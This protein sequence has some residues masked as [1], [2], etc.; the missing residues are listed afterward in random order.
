MSGNRWSEQGEWL[1]RG[2]VEARLPDFGVFA[3][4]SHHGPVFRM[5]ASKHDFL[6]IFYILRGSGRIVIEDDVDLCDAGDVVVVPVGSKHWIED[7]PAAPLSLHG[8]CVASRVW[9]QEPSLLNHLPAG[10]LPLSGLATAQV[11]TDLR[12]LLFE[13]SFERPGGISALLG[14]TL[15]LLALLAR[16]RATLSGILRS[17]P[18]R[19]RRGTGR[20]SS[21]MLP[22]SGSGSSSRPISTP[23]PTASG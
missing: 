16:T 5:A 22:N 8:L 13:Q 6:E 18:T 14:L 9:R 17:G 3:L 19:P 20:L 10:R 15:Q 4:E 1:R 21:V 11:R 12:R 23:W 7:A 2:P